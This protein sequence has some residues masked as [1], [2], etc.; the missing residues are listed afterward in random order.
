MK[1]SILAVAFALLVSGLAGAA[2]FDEF[3]VTA[4][5]PFTVGGTA[6]PAGAYEIAQVSPAGLLR[7]TNEATNASVLVIGS[8]IGSILAT[9]PGKVTFTAVAGKYALVQVY[10]PSG[11]SFGLPTH[12]TAR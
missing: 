3:R 9:Q 8:P 5:Q 1:K 7:I 2:T 10:L 6:L 4:P 11:V 12:P